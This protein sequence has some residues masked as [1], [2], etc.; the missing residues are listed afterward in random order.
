MLAAEKMPLFARYAAFQNQGLHL[1]MS[2]G[3]PSKEQLDLSQDILTCLVTPDD[4]QADGV[5]SRSYGMPEGLPCAR[6]L[7]AELLEVNPD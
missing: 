5:D 6:K 4:Y 7:F 2:R 1:N 3:I